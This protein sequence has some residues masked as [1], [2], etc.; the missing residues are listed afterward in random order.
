MTLTQILS[1]TQNHLD[2]ICTAAVA[3]YPAECCGLLVGV[4]ER[5][6]QWLVTQVVPTPNLWAEK[7]TDRFAIDPVTHCAL[8]RR[9]RGRAEH[10]IGHYH[11]HPNGQAYPSTTDR[12]MGYEP[13]LVWVIVAVDAVDGTRH[14]VTTKAY[15]VDGA[16]IHAV[17]IRITTSDNTVMPAR[18]LAGKESAC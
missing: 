12:A 3:A 4:L 11:S 17:Q 15:R 1:L 8:I 2:R 14:A 6:A 18:N 13:E 7:R 9:L 5:T 16:A 10:L